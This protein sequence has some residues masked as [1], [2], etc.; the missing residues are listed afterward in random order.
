MQTS[1]KDLLVVGASFVLTAHYLES[2]VLVG[3]AS[4]IMTH[5]YLEHL[6]SKRR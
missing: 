4:L 5:H 6:L 2:S 1:I 3:V